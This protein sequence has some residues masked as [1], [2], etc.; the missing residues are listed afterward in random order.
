[1]LDV[2]IPTTTGMTTDLLQDL[3]ILCGK[4]SQFCTINS[5]PLLILLD[6]IF[7]STNLNYSTVIAVC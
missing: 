3:Y 1:M 2:L 6:L 7:T 4:I 5:E